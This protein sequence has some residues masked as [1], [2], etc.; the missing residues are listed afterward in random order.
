MMAE[1]AGC[2]VR[3]VRGADANRKITGAADLAWAEW[4]AGRLDAGETLPDA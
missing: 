2:E 1:R 4:M 3:W